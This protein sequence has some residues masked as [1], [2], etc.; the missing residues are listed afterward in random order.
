MS[1]HDDQVDFFGLGIGNDTICRI[2]GEHP[3]DAGVK[4]FFTD[5]GYHFLGIFEDFVFQS[6]EGGMGHMK[7]G[8]VFEIPDYIKQVHL[9][10]KGLGHGNHIGNYLF[11][12]LGEINGE[13][14]IFERFHNFLPW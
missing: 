2:P 1:S 9:G 13:Q 10:L 7:A 5:P 11:G 3:R 8:Q 12:G 4:I 14:N 6:V